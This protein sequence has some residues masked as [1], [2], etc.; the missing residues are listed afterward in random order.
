MQLQPTQVQQLEPEP[1]GV[2]FAAS[3]EELA[4]V[5]L[6]SRTTLRVLVRLGP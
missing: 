4:R 2:S 5:N 3:F 1:G 6:W